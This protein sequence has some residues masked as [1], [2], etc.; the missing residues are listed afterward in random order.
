MKCCESHKVGPIIKRR[1]PKPI[2]NQILISD[3]NFI[4]F[5]IPLNVEMVNIKVKAI[6]IKVWRKALSVKKD[7]LA[8]ALLNCKDRKPSGP[9][10]PAIAATTEIPSAKSPRS[11][12]TKDFGNIGI[13][14][15]LGFNGKPLWDSKEKVIVAVVATN[16]QARNPQWRKLTDKA[17]STAWAVP[18]VIFEK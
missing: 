18:P 14:R 11:P 6:T 4:P 10:V 3:R 12:S 8:A 15:L 16:A 17:G 13:N 5:W 2:V 7:N 9:T 1:E